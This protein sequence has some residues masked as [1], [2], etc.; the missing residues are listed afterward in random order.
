MAGMKAGPGDKA[1]A[2]VFNIWVSRLAELTH[3]IRLTIDAD[4]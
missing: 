4:A 1:M 3:T 2:V